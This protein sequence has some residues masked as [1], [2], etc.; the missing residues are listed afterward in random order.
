ME[1]RGS[2]TLSVNAIVIL[3]MAIAFLGLG[4]GFIKGTF[5]T[6]TRKLIE[7][8]D[9]EQE[10]PAPTSSS[11][12]SL[13]REMIKTEPS[14]SEVIK[15]A[16]MN[17]TGELW[18]S[19]RDL[20]GGFSGCGASDRICYISDS[21]DQEDP[22]CNGATNWDCVDNDGI[23]LLNE[24][25]GSI[26]DPNGGNAKVCPQG[27]SEEDVDC[28]PQKNGIDLLISCENGLQ[29]SRVSDPKKIPAGEVST[30]MSIINI[31]NG[32]KGTFL[33]QIKLYGDGVENIEK[34]LTI[35]VN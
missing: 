17:P 19:R 1:K 32:V 15:I 4:I 27:A 26:V 11:P 2:L 28:G 21:C 29:I 7:Q 13:S 14:A 9:A 5:S 31:K 20:Y 6:T 16:V 3:I 12:I 10:P 30:F 18:A 35:E 23:C 22:D 33:C 25:P 34:D 24:K 8:V